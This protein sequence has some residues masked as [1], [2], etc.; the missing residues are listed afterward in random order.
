[1][2]K[3]LKNKKLSK[4]QYRTL[5]TLGLVWTIIFIFLFAKQNKPY[6]GVMLLLPFLA[7]ILGGLAIGYGIVCGERLIT[8]E[9]TTSQVKRT[10]LFALATCVASFVVYGWLALFMNG[11]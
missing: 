8:K 3:H 5:I 4:I 7:F 9:D 1:M 2:Q 11:L 6:N 10:I